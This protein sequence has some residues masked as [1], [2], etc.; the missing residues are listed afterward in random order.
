M[1]L[2]DT[3]LV[4]LSKA[5]QREDRALELLPNLKGGAAQKVV[6]KLLAERLVEEIRARGSL[7][8]W[9]SD[10]ED[11]P[12]ALRITKR[13]LAAFKVKHDEDNPDQPESQTEN[14]A[15]VAKTQQVRK[16]RAAPVARSK[17]SGTRLKKNN[18]GQSK[19]AR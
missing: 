19:Q 6:A 2:T 7:P 17:Q 18:E 11:R 1:K 9:R 15:G 4:L 10:E 5:S 12:V 16:V 8:I 3:Q 14:A 13:G